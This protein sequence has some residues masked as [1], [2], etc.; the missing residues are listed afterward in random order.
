VKYR[1]WITLALM[2]SLTLTACGSAGTRQTSAKTE[3]AGTEI[4]EISSK[5]ETEEKIPIRVSNGQSLKYDYT[6][7][8]S[9][10]LDPGSKIGMVVKDE[11]TKYWDAIQEGAQQAVDELNESLGYKGKDQIELIFQGPSRL[12][13]VDGQVN[14]VDSILSEN[15]AA[16]CIAAIDIDSLQAQMETAKDNDIPIVIFDSGFKNDNVAASCKTDNKAAGAFAAEKLSEK[17]GD[18][19]DV[20]IVRQDQS[21]ETALARTE[22][23]KEAIQKHPRIRV[24]G[25]IEKNEDN[26]LQELL[27]EALKLDPGIKGILCTTEKTGE[28]IL[29][30]LQDLEQKGLTVVGMDS[31]KE[32]IEAVKKGT[33]YG[34]VSQD[35]RSMGYIAVN[36][37]VRAAEKFPIDQTIYTEYVWIDQKA[38]ESG[39]DSHYL[40]E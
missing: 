21:S 38:L 5:S 9:L 32:Q 37:A 35:P 23:A 7:M 8:K 40:Y 10:K 6:R 19:G 36:T 28:E 12:K 4:K 25:M 33:E 13:N 15:P 24:A 30:A 27:Q 29:D 14:L 22:G 18:Q 17:M 11:D 1:G 34:F 16:I 31:G 26:D 20:L 39:A 3:S 2:A